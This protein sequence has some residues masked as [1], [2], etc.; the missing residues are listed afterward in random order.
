[1]RQL[2]GAA[3]GVV[4]NRATNYMSQAGLC[5]PGARYQVL[6][7]S[8][9]AWCDGRHVQRRRGRYSTEDLIGMR[10][11]MAEAQLHQAGALLATDVS[12]EVAS[13][14]KS[15]AAI[16]ARRSSA[17]Q[18][19]VRKSGT[20][21][22]RG[23]LEAVDNQQSQQQQQ[24]RGQGSTAAGTYSA[25]GRSA[26]RRQPGRERGSRRQRPR[27]AASAEAW[28]SVMESV[29]PASLRASTS[30][31][32][33]QLGLESPSDAS[34]AASTSSSHPSPSPQAA[35]TRP[36][37]VVDLKSAREL[38]APKSVGA[39]SHTSDASSHLHT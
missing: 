38:E 1:M 21:S 27:T 5:M 8:H 22:L 30:R 15:E 32:P 31:A 39:W 4:G 36:S 23:S 14:R 28:A 3:A 18:G 12:A 26:R 34:S 29:G 25:T 11:E 20:G 10:V 35:G 19:R 2:C 13:A 9:T 33:M 37:V 17:M 7:C 16:V 6:H 24:R